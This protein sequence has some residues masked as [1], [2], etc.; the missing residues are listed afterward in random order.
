MGAKISEGI[1]LLCAFHKAYVGDPRQLFA[2]TD[3][4]AADDDVK[5]F[6]QKVVD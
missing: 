3:F 1:F 2:V 6:N 5:P 4:N